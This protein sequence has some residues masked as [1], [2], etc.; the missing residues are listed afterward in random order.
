MEHYFYLLQLQK[1][2]KKMEKRKKQH[3]MYPR[4]KMQYQN[5]GTAK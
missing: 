5:Q 2:K 1:K 3:E 4:Y